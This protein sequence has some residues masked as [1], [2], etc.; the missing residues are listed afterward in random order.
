MSSIETLDDIDLQGVLNEVSFKNKKESIDNIS[1]KSRQ[2]VNNKDLYQEFL[3]YRPKVVKALEKGEQAPTMPDTIAKACIQIAT[4][5]CYSS[6]FFKY[7]ADWKEEMVQDAILACVN[8]AYK[9]D[10]EK[11]NNPFAYITSIVN[12]AVYNRLNIEAANDY[13]RLKQYDENRG[14][15][16][17]EDDTITHDDLEIANEMN[18]MYN[19][20]LHKIGEYEQ[21]FGLNKVRKKYEKR[22][23]ENTLDDLFE[24]DENDNE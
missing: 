20:R 12:N 16:A 7:S 21:R 8:G 4:R 19:D 23:Q 24:G 18:D 2:Y 13:I 22:K 3:K 11:S 1:K 15:F 14:F 9:F 10:P 5:R 6:R 17:E